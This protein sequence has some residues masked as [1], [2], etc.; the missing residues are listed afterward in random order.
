MYFFLFMCQVSQTAFRKKSEF[1][2]IHV[3]ILPEHCNKRLYSIWVIFS[4]KDL[5]GVTFW[6]N[7]RSIDEMFLF[8]KFEPS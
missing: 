8:L 5:L 3:N 4:T 1:V 7:F 6:H 2:E